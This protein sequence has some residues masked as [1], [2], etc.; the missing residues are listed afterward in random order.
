MVIRIVLI[1]YFVD[2]VFKI[3]IDKF[4]EIEV[5]IFFVEFIE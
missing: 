1:D 2:L 4:D 3:F 5:G